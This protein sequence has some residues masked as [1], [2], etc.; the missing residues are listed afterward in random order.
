LVAREAVIVCGK[1]VVHI[2]HKNKT[3]AIKGDG[4]TS[5]LKVIF[6][7]K[8]RKYIEKGCHLFQAQVSEKEPI[9]KRVEDVPVIH[10]FPKPFLD[11]LSG[12]P[13][14]RKVEF[15]IDLVPEATHIA[16]ASYRLAPSE[17]KDL[18][19]QL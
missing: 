6:C 4:S 14:P 13:P 16:H 15:K 18:S 9:V 17:M 10:D 2:P 1:K 8:A 12:L 11:N 19:D 5:Q 3:L 7:I